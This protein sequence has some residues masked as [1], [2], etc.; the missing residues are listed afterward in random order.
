MLITDLNQAWFIK[1]S[2]C[3]IQEEISTD[4]TNVDR[5]KSWL[6]ERQKEIQKAIPIL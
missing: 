2:T 6:G 4:L 3:R 5:V 1:I